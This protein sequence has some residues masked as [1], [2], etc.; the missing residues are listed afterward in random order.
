MKFIILSFFIIFNTNGMAQSLWLDSNP[1]TTGQQ[2]MKVGA[3]LRV[4]LKEGI[5]ADYTFESGKDETVSIKSAPDKKIVPEIMGYNFDRS[6]AAKSNGKE[7][8]NSKIL[9]SM[10]VQVIEISETGILTVS[11]TREASFEKGKS[12]LKLSG[13]VSPTDVRGNTIPSDLVADLKLEYKAGP[14]AKDLNDPDVQMKPAM[15][16]NGK[17]VIGPDGQPLQK[18]ELSENEKQKIILKNIRKL[19][20]ESE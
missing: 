2:G 6:I 13:K 16:P 15:A 1:Y 11:G 7:K 4:Q 17:P 5:K 14:I 19:L 3:V 12:L 20:G 8:S 9:G 18:A 10:A